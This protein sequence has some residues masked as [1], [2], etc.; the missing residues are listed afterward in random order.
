[1]Y[2]FEINITVIKE[3]I[4]LAIVGVLWTSSSIGFLY[5]WLRNPGFIRES[6]RRGSTN[7]SL[8][9]FGYEYKCLSHRNDDSE[10][11]FDCILY[12]PKRSKHCDSCKRCVAVYDHHCPW[13]NNCVGTNNYAAFIVFITSTF[14]AALFISLTVLL[15]K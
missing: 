7:V 5:S 11:C 13:I 2:L 15:S 10:I 9:D 12:R 3:D 1:M 14:F 4:L 6:K 8:R